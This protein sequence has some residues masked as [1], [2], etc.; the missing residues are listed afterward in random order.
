MYTYYIYIMSYT[1]ILVKNLLRK[2]KR[3]HKLLY[4]H[5]YI[6]NMLYTFFYDYIY[7]YLN[8]VQ[9]VKTSRF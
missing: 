3:P 4:V 5:T 9:Q 6:I 7:I 2:K 1:Y 8:N